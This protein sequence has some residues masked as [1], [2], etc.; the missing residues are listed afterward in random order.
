MPANTRIST[1]STIFN[2]FVLLSKITILFLKSLVGLSTYDRREKAPVCK[3]KTELYEQVIAARDFSEI[4]SAS[5]YRAR[6]HVVT[7]RDGY[8]LVVHKLEK[9]NCFTLTTRPKA[10]VYLHHGL[11]TNSELWVL[12]STKQKTLPYLLVDAGYDVYLGNNRGNKY[13]RKHLNLSASDPSFWD[14][15]LDEF[16]YFDIPDTIE[17]IRK[18]YEYKERA[19]IT[20]PSS[21][22]AVSGDGSLKPP[23]FSSSSTTLS[24]YETQDPIDI[25]YVGFSQGCSQ[26]IA[27]LSLYPELNSKIKL[28]I[29]LSPAIIPSNL[30]HPVFKLIV[31]QTAADNRFLYSIFGRRAIMPS[32]SFWST[33]FGAKLYERVVD[34]SLSLL[35]GWTGENISQDQ[36]R[37]GYPHMFSNSSVKSLV[38]WFQIIK[39]ERFQMFDETCSCGLTKLSSLSGKSKEKGNRVTPFPIADHLNVPMYM[40]YGDAD[41]LVDIEKTRTLIVDGNPLMRDKLKVELCRSYEHMDTLWGSCVYED[42]FEKILKELDNFDGVSSS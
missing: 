8:L 38:H 13:S 20:G 2:I 25:V 32:V 10:V 14:F 27:S 37:M 11:L 22:N 23:S 40:F 34:K 18:L 26:L 28:F 12:G 7:T 42:V 6:E 1:L 31:N 24:S 17:Y 35:F 16:S 19:G 36:K 30:N 3:D 9:K 21:N 4:V 41:I 33:I 39:A 5:G 15:S 29:G